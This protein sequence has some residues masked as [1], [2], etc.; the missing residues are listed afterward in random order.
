MSNAKARAYA[1]MIYKGMKTINDVPKELQQA[2]TT[3]YNALY[4][5]NKKRGGR[6][7]W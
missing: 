7:K 3:A 4:S 1:W 6:R 2:T 5:R